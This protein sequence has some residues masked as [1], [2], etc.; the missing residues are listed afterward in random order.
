MSDA[1]GGAGGGGTAAIGGILQLIGS[2]LDIYGNVVA[3]KKEQ[4]QQRYNAAIARQEAAMTRELS[5]ITEYRKRKEMRQAIGAQR[6]AYAKSGVVIS[7]GSPVDVL[8]DSI[9]NAELDIA[10]GK[11]N[12]EVSA[13]GLESEARMREYYGKQ[14]VAMSWGRA[15][16]KMFETSGQLYAMSG[17]RTTAKTST[18]K[19]STAQTTW[20]GTVNVRPY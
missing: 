10:I 18:D 17:S 15:G 11:F 16:S 5:R 14:A 1:G 20:G 4:E 3:G 2:G 6:A 8:I 12:S 7:T 13:R 19:T 9:A